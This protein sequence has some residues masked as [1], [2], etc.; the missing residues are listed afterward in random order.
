M[1]HNAHKRQR[2]ST[3]QSSMPGNQGVSYGEPIREYAS[4]RDLWAR[5]YTGAGAGETVRAKGLWAFSAERT[6]PCVK[7]VRSLCDAAGTSRSRKCWDQA[8]HLWYCLPTPYS[9]FPG[10]K[11]REPHPRAE[12]PPFA[13]LY[14]PVGSWSNAGAQSQS[15]VQLSLVQMLQEHLSSKRHTGQ[16]LWS[17]FSTSQHMSFCSSTWGTAGMFNN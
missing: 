2:R 3:E 14:S 11:R 12:V 4:K 5:G 7:W 16:S 8:W 6:H 13:H 10:V 1:F 15:L 9:H 17:G